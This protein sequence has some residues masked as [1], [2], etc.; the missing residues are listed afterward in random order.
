MLRK[1]SLIN[2][3]NQ[4]PGYLKHWQL[5]ALVKIIFGKMLNSFRIIPLFED[6]ENRYLV[7]FVLKEKG[8]IYFYFTFREKPVHLKIN[9][10]S[11]K[12]NF[13]ICF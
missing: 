9:F 13:D 1:V 11:P 4:Q 10:L 3:Q 2:K 12:D 5:R 7:Y 6:L 8:K